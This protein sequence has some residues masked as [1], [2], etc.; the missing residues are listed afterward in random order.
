MSVFKYGIFGRLIYRYA[1][2]FITIILLLHLVMLL[3]S[4]QN[5]WKF[6]FPILIYIILIY[7]I[8]R[9]YFKVYKLFPFKISIDN[10]K[11]ICTDF[12]LNNATEIKISE[13]ERIEGS[14]F[15][16]TP[17]KPV[18]IYGS[19]EKKRIGI[20]P[21]LPGFDKFLTVLLS[22]VKTDLYQNLVNKVKEKTKN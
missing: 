22:N 5:E 15:S 7:I 18:Y 12:V 17:T 10:E 9:H 13:I 8:N 21:T 14:I 1:N 19:D 20:Y 6:I 11:I 2:I 16:G 3:L 4:I